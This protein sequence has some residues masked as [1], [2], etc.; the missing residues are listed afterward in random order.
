MDSKTEVKSGGL[1]RFPV[2]EDM[3]L[4]FSCLRVLV[5]KMIRQQKKEV[6]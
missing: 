6:L 2:G 3:N 4:F 1:R 5:K